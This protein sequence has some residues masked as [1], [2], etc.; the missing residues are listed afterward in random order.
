VS[1]FEDGK[2][3]R[4]FVLRR[5]KAGIPAHVLAEGVDQDYAA[6]FADADIEATP[7]LSRDEMDQDYAPALAAREAGDDLSYRRRE[8][9]TRAEVSHA[10]DLGLTE[11]LASCLWREI[12][13]ELADTGP[14]LTQLEQ[15]AAWENPEANG[16]ELAI[17]LTAAGLATERLCQIRRGERADDAEKYEHLVKATKNVLVA[18]NGPMTIA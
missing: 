1:D 18:W 15:I 14:E 10:D 3:G 4:Y 11:L 16:R 12:A 13:A 8:A 6:L 5:E 17:L 7:V 2:P 9:E